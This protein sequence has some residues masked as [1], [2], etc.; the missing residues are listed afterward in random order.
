MEPT[1]RVNEVQSVENQL[2]QQRAQLTSVVQQLVLGQ[3]VRPCGIFHIVGHSTDACPV[4]YKDVYAVERYQGQPR[5]HHNP[6]S[7]TYNEK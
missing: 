5:P 2:G 3:Q 4:R 7:Y 1:K 6:Y